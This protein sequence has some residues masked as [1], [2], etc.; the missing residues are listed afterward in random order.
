MKMSSTLS[1]E[2]DKN[3]FQTRESW[4]RTA[5]IN[6]DKCFSPQI[7]LGKRMEWEG[8]QEAKE[9]KML[10]PTLVIIQRRDDKN[11]QDKV[12][13]HHLSRKQPSF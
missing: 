1:N 7:T 9:W 5:V 12:C 8:Y 10:F 4:D 13:P 6:L 2:D 3:N 11:L